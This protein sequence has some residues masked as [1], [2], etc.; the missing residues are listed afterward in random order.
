MT[1]K[2]KRI[3][4]TLKKEY[5]ASALNASQCSKG[6]LSLRGATCK[7]AIKALSRKDAERIPQFQNTLRNMTIYTLHRATARVHPLSPL[8]KTDEEILV[9]IIQG[10]DDI[11]WPLTNSEIVEIVKT[12]WETRPNWQGANWI[13]AF[14][15]RH[16]GE[17][18]CRAVER[19]K[20]NRVI[21][22]PVEHVKSF[23]NGYRKL[24]RDYHFPDHAVLN[25]DETLLMS[26]HTDLADKAVI[27]A[28]N[29]HGLIA[30]SDP[31]PCGSL[32][33]CVSREGK[34][35]FVFGF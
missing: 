33:L 15:K 13:R 27:D 22:Q 5:A 21:N 29:P 12:K 25:L 4:P 10:F 11:Y 18:K 3:S 9:G 17:L 23:C 7:T 2:Y 35:A 28:S 6:K 19:I 1:R 34:V 32:L 26:E 30:H 16:S 31:K 24:F 20:P 8:T 14:L